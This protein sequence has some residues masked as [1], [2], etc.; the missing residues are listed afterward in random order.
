[1]PF[2]M[3]SYCSM[4]GQISEVIEL[5][6]NRSAVF[7]VTA[8]HEASRQPMEEV[9]DQISGRHSH[10]GGRRPLCSRVWSNCSPRSILD[11]EFGPA[12]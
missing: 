2:S 11:E 7:K 3:S 9:R 10:T 5:D 4:D 8:H 1:M 6:N 12:A